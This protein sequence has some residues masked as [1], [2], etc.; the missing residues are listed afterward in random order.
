MLNVKTRGGHQGAWNFR[1]IVLATRNMDDGAELP[2]ARGPVRG[3]N[4]S[5]RPKALEAPAPDWAGGGSSTPT[6]VTFRRLRRTTAG[7]AAASRRS[8]GHVLPGTISGH[9]GAVADRARPA[10]GGCQG[11][12]WKR[13]SPGFF[14]P[15]R[16]IRGT[17]VIRLSITED[18]SEADDA[19][20]M[21][22]TDRAACARISAS[23]KFRTRCRNPIH[24]HRGLSTG[25]SGAGRGMGIWKNFSDGKGS[26]WA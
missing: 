8:L 14:S 3:T 22:P 11:F 15:F 4:P 6:K 9:L 7:G 1:V 25:F 10:G 13:S 5:R 24:N 21:F 19:W 23:E 2:G 12:F 20:A 26:P 18:R 16:N 17:G